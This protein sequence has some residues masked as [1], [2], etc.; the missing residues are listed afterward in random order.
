MSLSTAPQRP[1]DAAPAAVPVPAVWLGATGVIPFAAPTL[2]LLVA[3]GLVPAPLAPLLPLALAAYGAVILSFL[4]GVHWG[5][6][7]SASMAGRT[8]PGL[9]RR[10]VISVIPSLVG[11]VALLL[12]A[13][14]GLLL[15]ALAFPLMLAVDLKAAREGA[16]PAW[17]PRLRI[18]LTACVTALLLAGALIQG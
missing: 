4:G 17:Y 13:A 8:D 16:V 18:P 9:A 6:G 5:L 15:L 14:T 3:P 11:W 1:A 2:L 12:P 10:L 7:L